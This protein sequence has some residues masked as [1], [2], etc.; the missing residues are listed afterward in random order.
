MVLKSL[1]NKIL[2]HAPKDKSGEGLYATLDELIAQRQYISY[3]KNFHQRL[4]VSNQAGDVKSAFKGRGIEYDDL[5]Q[6][7]CLGFVK[8]TN[9]QLKNFYPKGLRH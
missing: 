3:L 9:N 7:G 2:G 8:A 5:Y 4:K 1:K 6:L